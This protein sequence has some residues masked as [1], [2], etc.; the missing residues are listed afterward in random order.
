MW[1]EIVS[2]W[3]GV[4]EEGVQPAS[5]QSARTGGEGSKKRSY[6]VKG[7][8]TKAIGHT[9]TKRRG[10]VG[11]RKVMST[12][13]N[14]APWDNVPE[15]WMGREEELKQYI[16]DIPKHLMECYDI[17]IPDDFKFDMKDDSNFHMASTALRQDARLTNCR[18]QFAAQNREKDFW[19]I[20]FYLVKLIKETKPIH[21]L[22]NKLSKIYSSSKH[23][24]RQEELTVALT[25][26]Y[27]IVKQ[28]VLDTMDLLN[29]YNKYKMHQRL[30]ATKE[31]LPENIPT[32]SDINKAMQSCIEGKKKISFM[33]VDITNEEFIM[34]IDD[35]KYDYNKLMA[36]YDLFNKLNYKPEKIND[37]HVYSPK[38]T[39]TNE[40]E[41]VIEREECIATESM[42]KR[43]AM[44]LPIRFQRNNWHLA[45][46]NSL[47]GS[48]LY[49]LY[50]QCNDKGPSLLFVHT[51][52][53]EVLIFFNS[54]GFKSN[55]RSYYGS[56]ESFVCAALPLKNN[57]L[58]FAY[59][60]WTKRNQFFVLSD[61][62]SI[63]IGGGAT[64]GAALFLDKSLQ[65]GSTHHCE[66][67]SSPPL[68]RCSVHDDEAHSLGEDNEGDFKIIAL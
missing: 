57:E 40:D 17:D 49:A 37:A 2:W 6:S 9:S 11:S 25:E 39:M 47:H 63:N 12:K 45:Y 65:F 20:Y 19:R 21:I 42:R 34:K 54:T 23:K 67:F 66:T 33:L 43:I 31:E 30:G 55:K 3:N 10:S 61:D 29:E 60:G 22:K 7:K 5:S 36:H 38:L 4:D 16:F 53:N 26:E 8:H 14:I 35:I 13:H 18:F 44:H 27:Q 50:H 48:S 56:G 1:N 59:Y 62:D 58:H 32:E 64:G 52:K 15:H 51:S 24:K 28:R 68:T 46:S 41:E